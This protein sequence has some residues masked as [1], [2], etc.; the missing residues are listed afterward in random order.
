MKVQKSPQML[1]LYFVSFKVKDVI[2]TYIKI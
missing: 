1:S 2:A